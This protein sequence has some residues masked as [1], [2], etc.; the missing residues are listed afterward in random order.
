MTM[1]TNR[2]LSSCDDVFVEL[3]ADVRLFDVNGLQV[4]G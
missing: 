1:I 2:L 4:E 3:A